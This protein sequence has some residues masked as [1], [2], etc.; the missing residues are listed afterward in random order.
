MKTILIPLGMAFVVILIACQG[1]TV[2]VE[3]PADTPMPLPTYTPHPTLVAL[4]TPVPLPTLEPLPTLTPIPM[5][6]VELE[7]VEEPPIGLGAE[8]GKGYPYTLYVHCGVRDAHFDGRRW[9]ADPMLG[10]HNPPPGWTADDS[11]GVMELVREDL[12]VFTSR[13]GRTIKFIPW[14]SD[15]EWTGCY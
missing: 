11:R 12:A 5:P 9:M 8:V 4:P 6:T 10:N 13:S 1:E 3:V 14:P 7:R 15:V 2:T